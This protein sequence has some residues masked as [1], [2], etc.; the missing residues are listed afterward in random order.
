MPTEMTSQV[1]TPRMDN[2]A[3]LAAVEKLPAGKSFEAVER[4]IKHEQKMKLMNYAFYLVVFTLLLFFCY[5]IRKEVPL[6]VSTLVSTLAS[7]I[8]GKIKKLF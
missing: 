3:L 7:A 6:S 2:S 1:K 5:S 4:I 8:G